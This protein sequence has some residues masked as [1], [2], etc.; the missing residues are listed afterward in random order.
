MRKN[1]QT[2]KQGTRTYATI[3]DF[4][5][6]LAVPVL[7][8]IWWWC[9]NNSPESGTCSRVG[10]ANQLRARVSVRLPAPRAWL[11]CSCCLNKHSN[12]LAHLTSLPPP[13]ERALKESQVPVKSKRLVP[14]RFIITQ[15]DYFKLNPVF[16][17]RLDAVPAISTLVTFAHIH[18][19]RSITLQCRRMKW[20]SWQSFGHIEPDVPHDYKVV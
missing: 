17:S 6:V 7:L 10:S 1:K 2:N 3:P 20:R 13:G 19:S 11:F 14:F 16:L 5:C 4:L 18:I 15:R 9:I 12:C 8:K